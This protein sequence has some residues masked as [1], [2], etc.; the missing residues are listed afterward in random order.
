MLELTLKP[1]GRGVEHKFG[2]R[3]DIDVQKDWEVVAKGGDDSGTVASC[4]PRREPF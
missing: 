2:A 1:V 4:L 3:S